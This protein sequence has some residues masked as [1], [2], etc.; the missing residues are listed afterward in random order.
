MV[1]LFAEI[2]SRGNRLTLSSERSIERMI[3][4]HLLL[5]NHYSGSRV[6]SDNIFPLKELLNNVVSEREAWQIPVP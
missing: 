3:T 4:E 1:V 5:D 2:S 6:A